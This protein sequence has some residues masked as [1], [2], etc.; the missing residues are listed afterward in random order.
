MIIT[1]D[2]IDEMLAYSDE[3]IKIPGIIEMD[4]EEIVVKM[5]KDVFGININENFEVCRK[6][7]ADSFK[8]KMFPEK[9]E[10]FISYIFSDIFLLYKTPNEEFNILLKKSYETKIKMEEIQQYNK[11]L[12]KELNK[13]Y[14]Q[15]KKRIMDLE[16][17]I[18]DS[19]HNFKNYNTKMS[20]RTKLIHDVLPKLQ[21][22]IENCQFYMLRLDEERKKLLSKNLKD[23]A[24][25]LAHSDDEYID[26][27]YKLTNFEG[28]EDIYKGDTDYS[29]SIKFRKALDMLITELKPY[30]HLNEYGDKL[31]QVLDKYEY[32][33]EKVEEIREKDPT[34]YLKLLKKHIR[35]YNVCNYINEK[36]ILNH[37]LIH[38][39][40]IISEAI[41]DFKEGNYTQFINSISPQI[42]GLFYDISTELGYSPNKL[43]SATLKPK[44]DYIDSGKL[45][46]GTGY[47]KFYFSI[48]RN[49]VAHGVFWKT[50]EVERLADETLLD[51]QYL[52]YIIADT[53]VIPSVGF[54]K[55]I[56]CSA[57][58]KYKYSYLVN[59]MICEKINDN[60]NYIFNPIYDEMY[61]FY[62]LKDVISETRIDIFSD[63]FWEKVIYVFE[64][65]DFRRK[66]VLEFIDEIHR[67][68]RLNCPEKNDKIIEVKKKLS[69]I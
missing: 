21:A 69:I 29:I 4:K 50:D 34:A 68:I 5:F 6:E 14:E 17:D 3:L 62:N 49:K 47:F 40:V 38:R 9:K 25:E 28:S 56:S 46:I 59:K 53:N 10:E 39:K 58:T 65:A 66:K 12:L 52:I 44:I 7:F 54:I 64:H 13:E 23:R 8:K 20:E 11:K 15:A 18:G 16:K 61:E 60:I 48:I 37:I 33:S 57:N 35:D 55:E 51:L 24:V 42:E 19:K 2:K 27:K 31:K 63:E 36:I 32:K 22:D 45:E 43:N 26:L 41:N 30:E 1:R 67:Y